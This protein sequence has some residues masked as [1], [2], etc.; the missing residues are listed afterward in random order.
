MGRVTLPQGPA[1]PASPPRAATRFGSIEFP[2]PFDATELLTSTRLIAAGAALRQPGAAPPDFDRQLDDIQALL[3]GTFVTGGGIPLTATPGQGADVQLWLFGSSGGQSAQSAGARGLPFVANYHVSPGTTLEAVD[4]YRAAFRPSAAL[5]EPYVVVSAD[6]LA[7][8]TDS[9]AK[10][11]AVPYANW[12]YSIRS[13]HGAIPYPDPATVEPLTADQDALV[14]DRISTRF[15]GTP[16]RVA[17]QL[18]DLQKATRAQELVVTTATHDH[19][20]RLRSFKLV[21]AEWGLSA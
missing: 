17:N 8:E 12:V 20:D 11:L 4:A 15:V 2:A 19:K 10:H 21:A 14:A 3:D 18:D 5:S 16:D 7:A 6:V 9:E 13:G 1:A